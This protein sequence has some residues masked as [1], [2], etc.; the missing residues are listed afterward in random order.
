MGLLGDRLKQARKSRGYTQESL[1]DTIGVSR[2]VIFNLETNKTEP[3]VIVV[4][5]LCHTLQI[6]REWL[7]RG[8]GEMEAPAAIPCSARIL[9]EL[10]DAMKG[11]SEA[12]Q[13]YLL[14]V[15]KALKF[16]LGNDA[17]Q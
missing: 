5:A 6:S 13:L 11:L 4:N 15:I 17:V 12:E 1:A 7:V 10:Y 2:G 3:Q 9:T 8:E 16:R 14:D